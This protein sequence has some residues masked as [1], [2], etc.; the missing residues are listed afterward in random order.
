[1]MKITSG[2]KTSPDIYSSSSASKN[3]LPKTT[4][5]NKTKNKTK[6]KTKQN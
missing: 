1:M 5:K 4:T 2:L 6:Q 3:N